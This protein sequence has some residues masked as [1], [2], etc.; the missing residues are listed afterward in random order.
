[1]SYR[2]DLLT[3]VDALTFFARLGIDLHRLND[4]EYQYKCPFHDDQQ[5]SANVNIVD[6]TWFCHAEVRGDSLIGFLMEHNNLRFKEAA[7][8][9]EQWFGGANAGHSAPAA[10][11]VP[12]PRASR[13]SE[14]KVAKWHEAALRNDD[15]MRWFHE[16]RGFTDETIVR[17]QLGWDGERVTIPVRDSAGDLVNVRRYKRDAL[18]G[19]KMLPLVSGS[20][21]A[22][23]LFPVAALAADELVFV[24]GE[25]D[26]MLLWQ[27]GFSA[28]TVTAG[29]GIFKPEW[30]PLFEHKKIAFIPDNDAPGQRGASRIAQMLS[31]TAEVSI[32]NVPGLPEKGDTTDFFVGGRSADELRVLISEATPFVV[33]AGQLTEADPIL[34]PL[35]L[36]SQARFQGQR[37]TVPVLLSGKAMTPY[38]VPYR[39]TV[40]C[41]MSNRRYCTMCPMQAAVGRVEV[42]LS[43]GDPK[44]LQLIAVSDQQQYS[45]I[46]ALA[47][48]VPQCTRPQVEIH[49]SANIEELRVIPELD[50]TN[51]ATESEYVSRTAY[52][53][54]HGARS[55]RSYQMVG[56]AHPLPKSQAT[57]H[58]VDNLI[59][60]QDNIS[61]FE[62]N[63][64]VL[65]RLAV[66][67]VDDATVEA[68]LADI[69][70]DLRRN[71]HRIAGRLEMQ[72]AYDL[73]W[74]SVISFYFNGTFVRR[75]WTE[76][77]VLGDSGQGK[78]EM[79]MSL[80]SHYRLGERV[81]GE[82]ASGAGLIGGLEK[83]NET[84]ILGWGRVPLNDK[85]LLIIDETQGLQNGQIESMSDVRATGIAEITKIRTERTN[86]RCR[87]VWL[88]NPTSGRPLSQY[89]QG[90]LALRDVFKKPEDIR[91]LDLVLGVAS[92]DVDLA[93][94][95]AHHEAPE[96]P[97]YSSAACRDLVLWAWSR[98]PDQ[99]IFE[100]AAVSAILRYATAMGRKYHPSLPIVEPADQRLKLAR[101]AVACAARVFS[102]NEAGE[103][104]IV[105]PEH[106][107]FVATYLDEI[108]SSRALAY[109]EY[110]A[111]MRAGESLTDEVRQGVLMTMMDWPAAADAVE[112][113][114]QAKVFRKTELEEVIGWDSQMAKDGIKYLTSQRLLRSTRDGYIKTPAFIGLLRD[115]RDLP[116][117][118]VARATEQVIAE[119]GRD[120]FESDS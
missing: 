12:K 82:Q 120:P 35:A 85:R 102:S 43:A 90:V 110:S 106:V 54:G 53:L 47:K 86:A 39:F 34:V 8:L 97:R 117:N 16:H 108:Y 83:M 62:V 1:M 118:R 56:Y 112:F 64:E 79:A 36:A 6:K 116:E 115:T 29:A 103:L 21:A 109:D 95:N 46:K 13:L 66:F 42:T 75:G 15:L 2:D 17:W 25:W 9:L 98:R 114:R 38:T 37:E 7:A 58:L 94:I 40:H 24:E 80:L 68:K 41:D 105:R 22:T 31:T 89:N 20:D 5:A 4:R 99:V 51:E 18:A 88:G 76:I 100:T 10:T 91:R 27:N 23:R 48:A 30:I 50:T 93:E 107:D 52:F 84:W 11:P 32:V 63:D 49:E 101:L 14:D 113:L 73:A 70:D 69:Y 111:Q 28:I 92:G 78:T 59:P 87:L 60:A 81:Q 119:L 57:V 3:R 26:A 71:V 74:H 77:M 67:R 55:N 33:P 44:V 104:V 96:A 45:A 72:V 65:Q 61:A 19:E